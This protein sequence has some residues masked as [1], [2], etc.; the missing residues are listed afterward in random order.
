[1]SFYKNGNITIPEITNGDIN[2][3]DKT[4]YFEPDDSGWIRIVHHNNPS[5]AKF[6]S[7]DS[8]KTSIYRSADVWFNASV[9]N[10]N[11]S[12]KW[13]LMIKQKLTSS[14]TETKYRFI[15]TVNPMTA[16]YDQ[17]VHANVTINTQSGYSTNANYG[18]IYYK[19]SNSYLVTNNA[20]SGNWYGALG[21]W[22]TYNNGIPGIFQT[23]ITTGYLDLYYRIDD[24]LVK[25]Y[26]TKFLGIQ[27]DK[28]LANDLMEY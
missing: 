23:T 24:S 28:I 7:T 20:A 22:S 21:C 19:N 17:T 2:P 12:G 13:E 27:S 5:S 15:Q 11:T 4:I 16:T 26:T 14:A 9:L 6:A 8:F 3:Y 25:T 10:S 18:G 1:M